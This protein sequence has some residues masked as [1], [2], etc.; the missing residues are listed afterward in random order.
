MT[1]QNIVWAL[2]LLTLVSN[3]VLV[4]LGLSF[5]LTKFGWT[6]SSWQSITA[7][8]QKYAMQ[9]ALIV[10]LTATSGSLYFS[11]IAGFEPC[12][13]CWFQRIFMYPLVLLL[14]IALRRRLHDVW[15]YVLPMSSIGLLIAGYHYYIQISPTAI[16]PCSAVGYAASCSERFTTS[17]GYITIPWMAASAFLL[18]LLLMLLRSP[19]GKFFGARGGVKP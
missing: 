7:F 13:L 18:I 16:I 11:E 9:S 2:A 8:F 1:P 12:K 4:Y 3:A 17:F 14:F 10:S 5:L 19:A 6:G 15:I